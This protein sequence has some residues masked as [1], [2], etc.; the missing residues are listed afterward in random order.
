MIRRTTE[1]FLND[2]LYYHFD[3]NF[4]NYISFIVFSNLQPFTPGGA[5]NRWQR[6]ASYY[7]NIPQRA[8]APVDHST[9]RRFK[10]AKK[11]FAIQQ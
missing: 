5:R 4:I 3:W 10:W 1:A 11:N 6:P 2:G 7:Q 8:F 9:K